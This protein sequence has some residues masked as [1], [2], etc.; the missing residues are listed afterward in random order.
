MA[1]EKVNAVARECEKAET[2][3]MAED[4]CPSIKKFLSSVFDFSY[5]FYVTLF[6]SADL[7]Q[8]P[9]IRRFYFAPKL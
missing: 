1:N 5:K 9:P 4:I 2:L 8:V 3:T 6:S 7:S